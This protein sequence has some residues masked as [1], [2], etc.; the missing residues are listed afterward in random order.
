MDFVYNWNGNEDLKDE[1]NKLAK[2][3]KGFEQWKK[4]SKDKI[5]KMK[6][7][8]LT[9]EEVYKWLVENN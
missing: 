3:Q 7:N 6:K 2:I 9:E 5:T 8:K 1:E 4:E